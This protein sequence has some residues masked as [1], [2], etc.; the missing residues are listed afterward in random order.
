MTRLTHIFDR[1]HCVWR[2]V[3]L[4]PAHWA[5][6]PKVAV[7]GLVCVGGAG[8][9]AARMPVQDTVPPRPPANLTVCGEPET[10]FMKRCDQPRHHVDLAPALAPDEY[11]FPPEPGT[12]I[13]SREYYFPP[14]APSGAVP[15]PGTLALMTTGLAGLWLVLGAALNRKPSP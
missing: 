3:W 1:V 11:Y 8:P 5:A 14:P 6:L 4:T 15:E 10:K 9:S 2:W 7:L 13:R 12:D